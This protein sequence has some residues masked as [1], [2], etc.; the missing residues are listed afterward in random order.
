MLFRRLSPFYF[1]VFLLLRCSTEDNEV[2]K[3]DPVNLFTFTIHDDFTQPGETDIWLLVNDAQGL[4]VDTAQI[5]DGKQID[6]TTLPSD[7][8]IPP[9]TVT[10]FTY[11]E[12]GLGGN[13]YKRIVLNSFTEMES[14]SYA[15]NG[16][17][18]SAI[19]QSL[20]T[21]YVTV[22]E[23]AAETGNFIIY[24]KGVLNETTQ[25][26]VA[27]GTKISIPLSEHSSSVSVIF[28]PSPFAQP[29]FYTLENVSPGS[30]TTVSFSSFIP[31]DL[32][33][34]IT[35]PAAE[36]SLC[37]V[38]GLSDETDIH[39]HGTIYNYRSSA[40][41]DPTVVPVY[42]TDPI[43][44]KVVTNIGY[45]KA[46]KYYGY[47][48]IGSHPP[49]AVESIDFD[50]LSLNTSGN[51]INL[52]TTGSFDMGRLDG[53]YSGSS[54]PSVSWSVYFPSTHPGG[55]SVPA[56]PPFL[57]SKYPVL[58]GMQVKFERAVL[59]DYSAVPAYTDAVKKV[60]LSEQF[61]Q[62]SEEHKVV[63]Y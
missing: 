45:I 20:G 50:V 41:D 7:E 43:A 60:L 3:E 38:K 56:L 31:M 58:E 47:D 63:M 19:S 1:L 2:A 37:I 53:F 32:F 49:A 54:G 42:F 25:E 12:T 55:I 57:Q 40:Q 9:Y 48:F 8:F 46:E 18:P 5:L 59:S 15:L 44:Q 52:T 62:T 10:T 33:S 30:S 23:T 14:G 24:G 11:S 34:A 17:P 35:F 22:S 29:S 4:L 61:L 51:F 39:S 28:T 21:A 6:I 16:K 27:E 13:V 26:A 36:E